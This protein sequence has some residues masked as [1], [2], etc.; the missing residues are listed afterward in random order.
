MY[1]NKSRIFNI[2]II[3]GFLLV[4]MPHTFAQ[5]GTLRRE[6]TRECRT[7][8]K[9]AT[10]YIKADKTDSALIYLDSIFILDA[11]NPDAYYFKGKILVRQGD[12]LTAIDLL[13]TGIEKAPRSTR[14][15][16]LMAGL[17]IKMQMLDTA[18]LIL[19]QIL[20]I[21]PNESEALYYKGNIAMQKGDTATAITLYEKGLNQIQ[22]KK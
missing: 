21:K 20:A 19:D 13:S 15:K 1:V 11:N 22:K 18:D 5:E 7:L 14:L 10:K 2:F 17:K 9:H 12:T 6:I 4:L 8:L 16:L 3:I